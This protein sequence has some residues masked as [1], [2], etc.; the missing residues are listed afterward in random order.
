MKKFKII[1]IIIFLVVVVAISIRMKK[2]KYVTDPDNPNLL[3]EIDT[4]DKKTNEVIAGLN[5]RIIKDATKFI[6]H[7]EK[8][9]F[10]LRVYSGFRSFVEQ[11]DLYEQGRS[12]PG[13]IVTNAKPGKSLHNYGLAFDLVEIKDGKALWENPNWGKIG[14][15]GKLFGFSWGGDWK[16]TDLVDKPH[17]ENRFGKTTGEYLALVESGKN[18]N[19]V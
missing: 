6:N 10:K 1:A 15:M 11:G 5:K 3:F 2:N 14:E 9:G 12:K 4:W 18:E 17:F 16:M 7:A 8:Q 19:E 13:K